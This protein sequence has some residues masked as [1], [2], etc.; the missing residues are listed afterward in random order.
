[1]LGRRHA[2]IHIVNGGFELE[3]LPLGAGTMINGRPVTRTRLRNGDQVQIGQTVL[4]YTLDRGE[5]PPSSSDLADRISLIA[6]QDGELSSHIVKAVGET[7]GSRIM[8]HPD[9]VEGPW[10]RVGQVAWA[11]EH[12]TPADDLATVLESQRGVS[13][14]AVDTD[15]LQAR[16]ERLPRMARRIDSA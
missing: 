4:V 16:I 11:G 9:Q 10:L 2:A 5:A 14:L 1:M 13:V 6:R 8:A 12:Y 3:D 7:E 15:A